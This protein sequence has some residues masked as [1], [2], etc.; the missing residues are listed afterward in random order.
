MYFNL[1]D[2]AKTNFSKPREYCR[3]NHFQG[4]PNVEAYLWPCKRSLMELFGK[5]VN[6]PKTP[7]NYL[8]HYRCLTG[9]LIHLRNG[10]M[11]TPI[12]KIKVANTTYANVVRLEPL[13]VTL[14]VIL[15][16]MNISLKLI[17]ILTNQS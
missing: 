12:Q 9:S 3:N 16:L 14:R 11:T 2:L 10:K 5:I 6:A 7:K 4:L 13:L 8:L 17:V 1:S 15:M